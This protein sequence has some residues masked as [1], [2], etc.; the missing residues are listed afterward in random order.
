VLKSLV[1]AGVTV[2]RFERET[3]TLADLIE[4]VLRRA[5]IGARA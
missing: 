2:S 3:L 1:A 4:R 5:G